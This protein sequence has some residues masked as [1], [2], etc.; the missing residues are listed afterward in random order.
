MKR[1]ATVFILVIPPEREQ[2]HWYEQLAM[3][4]EMRPVSTVWNLFHM[5]AFHGRLKSNDVEEND[6]VTATLVFTSAIAVNVLFMVYLTM[7]S[8]AQTTQRR[9]I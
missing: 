9:M 6:K 2:S 1:I 7:L 4:C 3:F 8:V 5:S